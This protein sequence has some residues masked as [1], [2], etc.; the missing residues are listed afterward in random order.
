VLLEGLDASLVDDADVRQLP[1]RLV[2]VQAVTDHK[3]IRDRKANEIR[4]V[5]AASLGP[6]LEQGSHAD[7]LCA[8]FLHQWNKLGHGEAGVNY[9]LKEDDV[10][11]LDGLQV[12]T[13][14]LDCR[15]RSQ[16]ET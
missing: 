4:L 6:L 15:E 13:G 7:A 1:E 8:G 10:A 12:N 9:I 3:M 5:T 14:D 16:K 11:I 2:V